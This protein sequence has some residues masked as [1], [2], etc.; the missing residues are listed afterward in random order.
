MCDCRILFLSGISERWMAT[1]V[2]WNTLW[3]MQ[4]EVKVFLVSGLGRDN[5]EENFG[6]LGSLRKN[7][8]L[9]K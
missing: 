3:E 1:S 7:P 2:P 6:I 8:N 4:Y 9:S 5:F